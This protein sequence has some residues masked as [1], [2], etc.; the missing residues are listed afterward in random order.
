MKKHFLRFLLV[1][2]TLGLVS[3][4]PAAPVLVAH[5]DLKGQELDAEGIKAVLLGKRTTF[6]N[7]RIIIV[8]AKADAAQDAFI[9]STLNQTTSQFQSHWRRLF[10]TGAGSAPKIVETEADAAAF[11]RSTPGAVAVVDSAQA[12][13]LAILAGEK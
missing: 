3:T 4:L 7:T 13:A 1:A 9:K 8:I 11:V 12:E 10:M 5:P 6:G 2:A